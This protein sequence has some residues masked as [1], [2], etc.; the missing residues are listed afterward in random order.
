MAPA[1]HRTAGDGSDVRESL[2]AHQL[3]QTLRGRP[4]EQPAF[5]EAAAESLEVALGQGDSLGLGQSRKAQ[6]Q[7]G[8]GD[9]S[10]LAGQKEEQPAEDY[11]QRR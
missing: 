3:A 8:D 11:A 6:A 4:P 7:V 5:Q 9:P 10:P 2:E 1:N